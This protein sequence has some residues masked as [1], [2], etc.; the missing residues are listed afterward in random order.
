MPPFLHL[1]KFLASAL[2]LF[3]A[4]LVAAQATEERQAQ[5][6]TSPDA[7]P[8][9]HAKPRIFLGGSID[10]GSAPNWQRSVIDAFKGEDIVILNPRRS[11]WNPAWKPEASDPNFKQQVEWELDALES[12]DIVIIYFAPGSQS[13]VSLLEMGLYARS[14]KLV[15]LCPDG[16]WRKG[17]VDITAAK[18]GVTQVRSLDELVAEVRVR[19]RGKR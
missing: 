6:I 9:S 14:G 18:Y 5:V 16:Y 12:S 17:N 15:I 19:L 2:V 13:P 11:D 10:M 7:L 1:A 8:D 3:A 4:P